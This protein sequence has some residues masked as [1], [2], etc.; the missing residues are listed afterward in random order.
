MRFPYTLNIKLYSIHWLMPYQNGYKRTQF[1][2]IKIVKIFM[3]LL[4]YI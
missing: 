4:H 2:Q 3:M 1:N